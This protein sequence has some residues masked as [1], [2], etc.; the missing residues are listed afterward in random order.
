L[1]DRSQSVVLLYHTMSRNVLI[2]GFPSPL[3]TDLIHEAATLRFR[4]AVTV[5][6][7]ETES[8]G[9]GDFED[10]AVRISWTPSSPI[11][12]RSVVIQTLAALDSLDEVIVCYSGSLDRL[13]VFHETPA[14]EFERAVDYRFKGYLHL[15]KEVITHF[16]R[17]RRGTLSLVVHAPIKET[18]SP[19]DAAM[20][21]AVTELGERLFEY[22]GNEPLVIRGFRSRLPDTR[23][24]IRFI[25]TDEKAEKASGRWIKY[26]GKTGLFSLIS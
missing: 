18:L 12:A 2:V 23:E 10:D 20:E 4:P 19:L 8:N 5:I 24:F 14:V 25:L 1:L 11:S 17:Q 16:Q 9:S 6:T 26:T 22:Y 15:L 21:A 13:S 3:T 7:D